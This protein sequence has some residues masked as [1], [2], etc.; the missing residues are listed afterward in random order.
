MGH[1]AEE[2][3]YEGTNKLRLWTVST[4]YNLYLKA[5]SGLGSWGNYPVLAE[6][7]HPTMHLDISRRGRGDKANLIIQYINS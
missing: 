7:A 3:V 6:L 5:S 1:Q 2:N 4:L